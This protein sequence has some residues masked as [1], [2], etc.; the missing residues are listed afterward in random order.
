M[1]RTKR[2]LYYALL[3]IGGALMLFVFANAGAAI[4]V[5]TVKWMNDRPKS[6]ERQDTGALPDTVY[7]V[8][9]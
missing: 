1:V 4:N 6:V 3:I 8:K 9:Y 5:L 2:G 7:R